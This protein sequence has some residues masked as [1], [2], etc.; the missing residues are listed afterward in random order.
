MEIGSVM[1]MACLTQSLFLDVEGAEAVDPHNYYDSGNVLRTS[2][3]SVANIPKK[4]S[5]IYS[6]HF[7]TWPIKPSASITPQWI[8]GALVSWCVYSG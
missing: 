8:E 1:V 3:R 4:M 5:S 7:G 2:V 6:R